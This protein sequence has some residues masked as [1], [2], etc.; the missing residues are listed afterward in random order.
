M[1]DCKTCEACPFAFTYESEYVQGLGC[2][3]DLYDIRTMKE[4]SGHN[5]SC[6]EDATKLCSGFAVFAKEHWP[7][8]DIKTGKLISYEDWFHHG[9]E[10]AMKNAK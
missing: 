6:H 10:Y 2:L 5:W 8:L 1:G 3:P 7:H 4:Q 9:P